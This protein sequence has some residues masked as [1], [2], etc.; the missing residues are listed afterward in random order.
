MAASRTNRRPGNRYAPARVRRSAAARSAVASISYTARFGSG[1]VRLSSGFPDAL[2][3]KTDGSADRSLYRY[4]VPIPQRGASPSRQLTTSK[5]PYDAAYPER[6]L[7]P[8][9]ARRR[10]VGT[11]TVCS[12]ADRVARASWA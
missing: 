11:E 1:Y 10:R 8:S 6:A 12:Y 2:A 4:V 7:P 3:D 9:D 5:R